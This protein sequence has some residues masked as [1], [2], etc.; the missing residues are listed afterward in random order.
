MSVGLFTAERVLPRLR[1]R[2]RTAALR[3][4][5][6][7]IARD[8]SVSQDAI[9][10]DV[11]VASHPAPYMPRGG[12]SLLHTLV[13]DLTRSMAAFA[14][15]DPSLNLG[16]DDGCPTDLAVLLASPTARPQNH[17]CALASIARRLR[18]QDVRELVRGANS[19]EAIFVALTSDDW[20]NAGSQAFV[21]R[22]STA[23]E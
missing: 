21:R 3:E 5:A 4:L 10:M 7:L 15:L 8:A 17:L 19:R 23:S 1:A 9:L 6:A 20:S 11:L 12:V 18:R 16:A 22:W 14:R 13:P 2:D